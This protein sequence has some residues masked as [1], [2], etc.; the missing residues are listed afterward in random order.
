M[1]IPC[2]RLRQCEEQPL[3]RNRLGGA[4]S[5]NDLRA[6]VND[7]NA[8]NRCVVRYGFKGNVEL[9]LRGGL[10]VIEGLDQGMK[11]ARFLVDIE[12]IE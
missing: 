10:K 3:D 5:V 6:F 7:L 11:A 4:E 12:V 2:R 8:R 9:A 1:E